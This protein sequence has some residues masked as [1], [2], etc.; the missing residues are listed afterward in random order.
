[1]TAC[2]IEEFREHFLHDIQE[3]IRRNWI[4]RQAKWTEAVAVGS[5]QFVEAMERRLRNRQSS[6]ISAEDGAWVLREEH[7][8]LFG[9]I[10]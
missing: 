8:G 7:G 3:R 5:E 10:N 1:V 4:E 2:K 9:V 6:L